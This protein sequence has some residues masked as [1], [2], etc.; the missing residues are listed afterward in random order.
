MQLIFLTLA[1]DEL[2]EAKRFYN[3]QQQGLG[4]SFQREAQTAARLI[5]ERPLAWQIEI[6]PV[7]RFI[8][9][10]FPYKMLYIIRAER[11]VVIAVA[12]QHRQPDYWVDRV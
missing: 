11:I 1:R 9:D 3:R 4:G 5:Q 7:R 6:D 8:F 2:A 10:R 12:H